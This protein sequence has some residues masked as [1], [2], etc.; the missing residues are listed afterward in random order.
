MNNQ[1]EE[2][3]LCDS[4]EPTVKTEEQIE[5][6]LLTPVPNHMIVKVDR[7]FKKPVVPQ[8]RRSD[9]TS[10]Q[11]LKNTRQ[12][13]KWNVQ[14]NLQSSLDSERFVGNEVAIKNDLM[15]LNEKV[16]KKGDERSQNII[17]DENQ[18]YQ[19]KE[20]N[21]V[22]MIKSEIMESDDEQECQNAYDPILDD[23]SS[24]YIALPLDKS[25]YVKSGGEKATNDIINDDLIDLRMKSHDHN[26]E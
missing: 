1:I 11:Q 10:I 24:K 16:D 9:V 5:M 15:S 13:A 4:P 8:M 17:F 6:L 26:S 14:S 23:E 20:Q 19:D 3:E 22:K 7:T 21:D 25:K 18:S 2:E 12:R